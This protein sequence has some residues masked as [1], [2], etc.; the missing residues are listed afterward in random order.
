M[1]KRDI[2]IDKEISAFFHI[3]K[4]LK[5]EKPDVFHINS[6][7]MGGLGALAARL[8]GMKKIIFTGHGWAFNEPRLGWQKFFIKILVWVT[9]LLSHKTICVSEKTREQIAYWPFIKSKL[10]VIHNGINTS[11]YLP[12]PVRSSNAILS[13]CTAAELNKVKGL[14]I[15]LEA[16][17]KFIKN[18]KGE[19]NIYGSGEEKANLEK[20]TKTLR[21]ENSVWF[22]E[23]ITNE[24]E[25]KK[26][27][28]AF[29]IFVLP[30]RS[31]A[32]PYAILEAGAVGIPV[33]A[34][35]VGGIP[36]IIETGTNGVLVEPENSEELFSTL[37][38]LAEN[39]NLR[40]RLGT[41]LRASIRENFSLE[42]MIEK[43]L[44]LYL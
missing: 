2:S 3:W 1:L 21:I 7:K 39:E 26:L 23:F 42:K 20:L 27:I 36:E 8:M 30:S 32:L 17:A 25:Y 19:L 34:T 33:I 24:I 16:W 10:T 14:D 28:T 6:S 43:T 38:L 35:R 5:K 11:Q 41:N 40:K 44:E 4:I 9:V 13:V 31:E 12:L 18:H 29:D 37:V 15:L 22:R